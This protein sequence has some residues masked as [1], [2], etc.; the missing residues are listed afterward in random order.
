MGNLESQQ[1]VRTS[2]F[3]QGLNPARVN[4]GSLTERR[5]LVCNTA[6]ES[7]LSLR[8][9]IRYRLVDHFDRWSWKLFRMFD[10]RLTED[11]RS[12]DVQAL[13]RSMPCCL[14]PGAAQPLKN[15][16]KTKD[17]LALKFH[18]QRKPR[19]L[20]GCPQ[21]GVPASLKAARYLHPREGVSCRFLQEEGAHPR[22][23][24]AGN[25]GFRCSAGT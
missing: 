18:H 14:D 16:C 4:P 5:N 2:V 23:H 22:G 15:L 3:C 17:G 21:A 7:D 10:P 12:H 11:E 9:T 8:A 25:R 19:I 1:H 13:L 20:A 6:L 24:P